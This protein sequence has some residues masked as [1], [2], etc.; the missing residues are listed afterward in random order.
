MN[1]PTKK[2]GE[3]CDVVIGGTPRRGIS[4]YWAGGVLPWVSIADLTR[5][6]R[7]IN[8]TKEKITEVITNTH[9]L[10]YFYL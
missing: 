5:N 3:V 2:L 7:E 4:K 10:N 9:Q 1:Y 6:G 8:E